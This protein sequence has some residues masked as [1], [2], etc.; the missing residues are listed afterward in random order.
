MPARES[1]LKAAD[2]LPL[3]SF[4]NVT[5][6]RPS[7]VTR[8][9][10]WRYVL[11][12]S[13]IHLLACAV[14]IPWLF[15]WT[16]V[17]LLIGG[18]YFYGG[19]G[20]NIAYH[21]LLTHRSFKCPHWVERLLVLVAICCLE[22]APASWVATHRRHH[23]DSDEQPDPHSP[24][25]SFFWSHIGWLL[26]GNR[27]VRCISAYDRFARDVLKD[28]FY[29]KL[30][31]GLLSA[32][33]YLIHTA[34]YFAFGFLVGWLAVGDLLSGVQLGLSVVT[35]GVLLRTVCVWHISWSVNSL[36]HLFGYRNHETA[37]NSRNNWLV[38]FL[39]SGEGW[40]NNHHHDP[41]SASN[42]HRWWEVDP[43][44]GII[45]LLEICGLAT[46][47]I[48][49]RHLRQDRSEPGSAA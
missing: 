21:R 40:H 7:T 29:L 30:Q 28:P 43:M 3:R 36:S 26:V 27:E 46:D 14:C 45:R 39:T 13:I 1:A 25:V 23:I 18:I 48:R 15:S 38:A 31:R 33:I 19:L 6:N 24:L 34:L 42:W 20:I 10:V 35:W 4:G 9:I 37:E 22:D 47:V 44:Y 11:P 5:L 12:I 16:G 17:A 32:W 2:I 41:A 8:Q 49:P